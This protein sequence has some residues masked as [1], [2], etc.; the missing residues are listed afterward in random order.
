MYDIQPLGCSNFDHRYNIDGLITYSSFP[1]RERSFSYV[2]LFRNGIIEAVNSEL[3][4]S[5]SGQKYI[6][7]TAIES[8]LIEFI[9]NYLKVFKKFN[10][11]PPIF[12]F[13]TL[14]DV[15]DYTIPRDGSW[16]F[17]IYPIDRELVLIPEI[18]IEN[19]KF[20]P[21]Q[22]LKPVF[23]SIWNACGIRRSLNYDKDGKW[24]A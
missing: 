12:L 23:D 20:E 11:E 4:W 8:K 3:L 9:P 16:R 15:K 7:I 19:L 10:I 21:S 18:I 17:K 1:K 14:I 2:Q 22:L 24:I 5:D 6:P 13:V